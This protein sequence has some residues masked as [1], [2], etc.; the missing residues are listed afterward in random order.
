MVGCEARFGG[1]LR[2]QALVGLPAGWLSDLATCVGEHRW[3]LAG[4]EGRGTDLLEERWLEC[5][6]AARRRVRVDDTDAKPELA[7]SDLDR[8]LEIGVV[9]DHNG[10]VTDGP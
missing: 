5:T 9:R 10:D 3:E 2:F 1:S 4:G 7:L 8:Q 6:A